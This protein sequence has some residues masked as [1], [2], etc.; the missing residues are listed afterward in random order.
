MIRGSKLAFVGKLTFL[1]LLFAVADIQS[2]AQAIYGSLVGTVTDQSGA[3][4]P[5][6]SITATETTTGVV[7]QDHT[8]GGGR[9]TI[10]NVLPGTY[11]IDVSAPG[12]KNF[13]QTGLAVTPNVVSRVDVHLQI[14][15]ATEQVTVAADAT[16]L[17]TD[18]A[19]THAEI[20]S[21]SV[22]TMPLG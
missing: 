8:D 11:K 5:N 22:A 4:V 20:T 16:Q 1:L 2:I 10:V 17:Q 6:A 13:N 12:F 15:Q 18:K 21:R 9:Y 19:D 7:R 3:V 14:G